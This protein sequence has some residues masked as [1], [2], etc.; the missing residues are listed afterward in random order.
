MTNEQLCSLIRQ[1]A[2][3]PVTVQ[4]QASPLTLVIE[5]GDLIPLCTTL[6]SHGEVYADRLACITGVDNGPAAATMEVIYHLDCITTGLTFALKVR[7]PR[8]HPEVPTLTGLWRSA[9]WLE[10]EIFDMYGIIF[11]GHPDLRRILM[12]ADWEG[13]PLR[14]DYVEQESYHDI[15]VASGST[16]D[17]AKP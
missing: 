4:E 9:D 5:A 10:R 1:G 6:R 3:G 16:S 2:T 8:D 13:Y 17:P 14:K 15:K 12:P 7:I 11:T